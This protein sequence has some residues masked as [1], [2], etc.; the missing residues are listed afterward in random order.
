[1]HNRI[2]IL[3]NQTGERLETKYAITKELH[4]HFRDILQEP[5]HQRQETIREIT[6]H[7]PK[8]I[9]EDKNRMCLTATTAAE[10]EQVVFQLK[11]GKA[12]GLDG[13][14]TNFFHFF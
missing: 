11:V 1:M 4:N 9:T 14:T 3:K 2:T 7:I 6:Q 5:N 13:F 8:L 12:P 10:V